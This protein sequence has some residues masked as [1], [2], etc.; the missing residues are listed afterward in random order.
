MMNVEY[1]QNH[2]IVDFYFEGTFLTGMSISEAKEFAET[3]LKIIKGG[4]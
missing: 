3:I 1:D 4:R 2:K